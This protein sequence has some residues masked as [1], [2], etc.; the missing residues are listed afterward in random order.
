MRNNLAG[1]VRLALK[2]TGQTKFDTLGKAPYIWP[3]D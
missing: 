3:V 2:I 1:T